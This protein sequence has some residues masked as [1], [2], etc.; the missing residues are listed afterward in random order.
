MTPRPATPA[1]TAELARTQVQAW[2]D[3]CVGL[4]PPEE[5][6][7][8]DQS[9]RLAHRQRMLAAE[10]TR[11]ALIPGL[12]FAQAGSNARSAW[13]RTGPRTC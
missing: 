4:L 11:V 10:L 5:T 8:R 13:R 9:R 7:A 2:A 6:A 1:D 3:T 12:G